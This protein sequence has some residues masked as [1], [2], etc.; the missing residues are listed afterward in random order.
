MTLNEL[1][2]VTVLCY[3]TNH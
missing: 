2:S 1:R 3:L